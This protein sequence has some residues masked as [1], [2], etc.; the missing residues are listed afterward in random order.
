MTATTHHGA[1]DAAPI[2]LRTREDLRGVYR[3]AS[4]GAVDKVIH[5]LDDHCRRYL[6]RCP[7]IVVSTADADGVC[8]GSPKGG[9]PGFV[10]VLDDTHVAFADLSG[11]NRLDSFENLV[12][13]PSIALLCLIP[14]LDETLRINGTATLRTDPDLLDRFAVGG[15]PAKVVVVV[16]VAEVYV[17]CA[18]AFRRSALWDPSS[19][20]DQGDLPDGRCMVR[21]H[22]RIDAPLDVVR[23]V[24]EADVVATLWK[25]GG[26]GPT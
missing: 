10:Q 6:A 24:Y 4:G 20:I 19:W 18:K 12:E 2:T 22:A 25:P 3:P 16:E 26:S 21:D 11:N 23:E 7:F 8:D 17:H 1:D 13:N 9:E 15:A 5:Q 14:G